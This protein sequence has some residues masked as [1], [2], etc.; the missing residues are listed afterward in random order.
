MQKNDFEVANH[1]K[2]AG[3]LQNTMKTLSAFI[4]APIE[5]IFS[6]GK[7]GQSVLC[8]LSGS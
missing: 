8:V 1:G 4:S 6:S 7:R 2:T 3:R 5:Q